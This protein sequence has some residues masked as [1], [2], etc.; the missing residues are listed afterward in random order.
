MLFKIKVF[1]KKQFK[2][3]KTY[4]IKG[5]FRKFTLLIKLLIKIQVCF[6]VFFPCVIIRLISPWI[7]I[8]IERISSD[9][10]SSFVGDLARYFCEKKLKI[11]QPKKRHL[12]LFYIPRGDKIHNK[13]LAKMWKRKLAMTPQATNSA[14]VS[15]RPLRT[16][17][18]T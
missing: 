8:R 10:Y 14:W 17:P 2:D 3:I 4:G 13:Q 12:D 1:L 18:L 6:L 16:P 11:N 5:L 9:N 15:N 7:I